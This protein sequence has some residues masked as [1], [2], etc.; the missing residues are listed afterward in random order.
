MVPF[1]NFPSA[2]G[3]LINSIN[4]AGIETFRGNAIESLAR[5]ICQNSLDAIKDN[6][7]PVI[8]EFSSFDINTNEFPGIQELSNVFDK[9][10]TTWK[11]R[12][13]KSED[14]IHK[15]LDI[16]KKDKIQFLRISD[17]NTKGLEGA[18]TGEIGSPWSSLV[19][20]AGSSNKSE[21]SGGSFGIGKSAPFLVSQFRTLFYSSFDITGYKSHIG[22]A[23]LMSYQIDETKFTL[24]NGY[25][26]RDSNSSAIPGLINLDHKFIRQETGTD[27]YVSAFYPVG[28]WEK[29][30][31]ESIIFNFFITIF[32]NKLIVRINDFEINSE[33]IG[34]LIDQLEDNEEN[35][36]LKN[37]FSVLTS[38]ETLKVPYPAKK[39]KNGISF[40]EGE[41]TLYLLNGE[42]LNRRVLMTRKTGMRIYEQGHISGSIS[43]TGILRITGKNMNN[44]F[45]QM[46][47]PA[48]NEWSPNRYEKDPKL[49]DKIFKELRRFIRETVKNN[50]QEKIAD[51]MDAVGLS[52]FLPNSTLFDDRGKER[53]ESITSTI[54]KIEKK[55]KKYEKKNVVNPPGPSLEEEINKHLEGAFGISPG[56]EST[57]NYLETE[58]K[59]G[60]RGGGASV[61]GGMNTLDP[62][63]EGNT[64]HGKE[65]T[66]RS[67]PV[68]SSYRYIC[69]DK[70]EGKYRIMINAERALSRARIKFSVLGEQRDFPLHIQSATT[71]DR[72]IEIE[73][74]HGDT[75]VLNSL[76]DKKTLTLNIKIDYAEYC[77]LGA[78]LYED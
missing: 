53:R 52:D 10:L 63:T 30:M 75:V 33:N 69:T 67:K 54:K 29:E 73:N 5:E 42:D 57:G 21:E 49:A 26:T 59:G 66:S 27:I 37:Y 18:E 16:L 24:G 17:F 9:C 43:F 64:Q 38:E 32:E 12:N 56:G 35:R 13:K 72:Y 62:Y 71:A 65:K 20:E 47:N 48:H 28:D 25:Y 51:S 74:I 7:K 2:T 11:G 19:K 58:T 4:H 76:E 36:N 60:N 39:Y 41:A 40:E 3:G 45:K 55:T 44:I 1:W 22:V 23:N 8:V 77:V 61:P 78:Q 6:D 34:V 46:E 15:A 14:F 50:F 70:K 68:A 31:L